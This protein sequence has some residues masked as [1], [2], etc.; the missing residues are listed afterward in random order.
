MAH[1]ESFKFLSV[2]IEER[3]MARLHLATHQVQGLDPVGPLI[4][5]HDLGVPQILFD[6]IVLGVPVAA[7]ALQG[8]LTHPESHV[9]AIGL[10]DG[11]DE[12]QKVL[13]VTFV[14][15]AA[16]EAP[17]ARSDQNAPV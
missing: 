14:L 15:H 3:S 12:I 2:C 5:G 13:V 1:T 11:G 4:E 7:K 8:R 6:G 10:D 9:R 17:R 16:R